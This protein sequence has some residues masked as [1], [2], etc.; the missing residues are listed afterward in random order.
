VPCKHQRAFRVT[1]FDIGES[2]ERERPALLVFLRRGSKKSSTFDTQIVS[3][4]GLGIS[5]R[6][7]RRRLLLANSVRGAFGVTLSSVDK[8]W[9]RRR[10]ALKVI[11]GFQRLRE[12]VQH[13]A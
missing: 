8:T 11:D 1:L 3:P 4:A 12:T 2:V 5:S 7:S 9:L 10:V 13:C 6:T